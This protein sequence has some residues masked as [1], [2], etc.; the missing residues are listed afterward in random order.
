MG[1]KRR[2][3]PKKKAAERQATTITV[4]VSAADRKVFDRAAKDSGQKLSDWI[5]TSLLAA[6]NSDK[7]NN[8]LRRAQESNPTAAV[9]AAP[10]G[11]K[12]L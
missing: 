7:M 10:G 9:T 5:R 12:S 4:R 11:V 2:G 6:V 3:R 1:K 8:H